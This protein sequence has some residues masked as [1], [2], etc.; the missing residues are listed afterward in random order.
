[1][2][3]KLEN[4]VRSPPPPLFP[5]LLLIKLPLWHKFWSEYGCWFCL[6]FYCYFQGSNS[7]SSADLFGHDMDNSSVDLTADIINRL[8][9]QVRPCNFTASYISPALFLMKLRDSVEYKL[10]PPWLHLPP[11][12]PFC[13][14]RL[15]HY[16]W[17]D[18]KWLFSFTFL[19]PGSTWYFQ[20][21]KHCRRD[22]K[23]ALFVGI[24]FNNRSS[25]QNPVILLCCVGIQKEWGVC[26]S[27]SQICSECKMSSL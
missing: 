10:F 17:V 18:T 20:P 3:K 2:I 13:Y 1:M 5:S 26:Y 24:H 15:L 6:S 7:I 22:R 8:S 4:L 16:F 11:T 9:F 27:T 19:S 12:P 25:G 21:K 14:F 23:E